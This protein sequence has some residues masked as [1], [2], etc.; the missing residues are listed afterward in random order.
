MIVVN[1]SNKFLADDHEHLILVDEFVMYL[2][3]R[4][5]TLRAER[6]PNFCI[7]LQ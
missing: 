7:Y 3:N 2:L 1:F 4:F 6:F 5:I